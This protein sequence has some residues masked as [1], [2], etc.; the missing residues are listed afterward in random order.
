M[1]RETIDQQQA[2]IAD[3]ND[4]MLGLFTAICIS[5]ASASFGVLAWLNYAQ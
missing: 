2:E 3:Q 5:L 1:T 4:R